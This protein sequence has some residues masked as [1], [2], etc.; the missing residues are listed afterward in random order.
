MLPTIFLNY[1]TID[2]TKFQVCIEIGIVTIVDH[3]IDTLVK[4]DHSSFDYEVCTV[5]CN[6]YFQRIQLRQVTYSNELT[7]N[8]ALNILL[9]CSHPG[10]I[11]RW[12]M[13]GCRTRKWYEIRYR[14]S[15]RSGRS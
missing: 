10:W 5:K 2:N 13:N 6:V 9:R 3:V 12:I 11:L 1:K 4:L 8:L 14:W 7:A 15:G